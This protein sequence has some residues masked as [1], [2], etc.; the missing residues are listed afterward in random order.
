MRLVA[1]GGNKE[2]RKQLRKAIRWFM[3]KIIESRTILNNIYI[4]VNITNNLWKKDRYYG[5]VVWIFDNHN[6]RH[7]RVEIDRGS[8]LRSKINTAAH[9]C[10]HI[11]QFVD[12]YM[13]DLLRPD[14]VRW[15]GRIINDGE[16]PYNDHP[17]EK[18]ARKKAR[19]LTKA[20]RQWLKE[21]Q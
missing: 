19:Q 13:K 4:R 20:Y 14:A 17:W 3:D 1:K 12:G 15:K 2:Q 21:T 7:F 8:S 18:E 16:L 9:E 11:K 5:S 10:W 6:P